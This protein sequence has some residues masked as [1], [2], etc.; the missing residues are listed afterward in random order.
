MY[1]AKYN[2][3]VQDSVIRWCRRTSSLSQTENNTTEA[4]PPK[5]PY[6]LIWAPTVIALAIDKFNTNNFIYT[7]YPM[8]SPFFLWFD[9]IR[10]HLSSEL[11]N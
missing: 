6:A 4:K 7:I 5:I 2:N 1:V 3:L 9:S 11:K 8:L 10:A